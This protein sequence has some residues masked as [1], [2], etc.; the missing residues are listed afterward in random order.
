MVAKKKTCCPWLQK[1]N[2]SVIINRL[3]FHW[4]VWVCLINSVCHAV[5]AFMRTMAISQSIKQIKPCRKYPW[6][7]QDFSSKELFMWTKLLILRTFLVLE[8]SCL[9]FPLYCLLVIW[10]YWE[11][12]SIFNKTILAFNVINWNFPFGKTFYP[13]LTV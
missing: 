12:S 9:V 7:H 10:T 4:N 6:S 2:H 13:K 8:L 3:N 1:D 11:S 5:S